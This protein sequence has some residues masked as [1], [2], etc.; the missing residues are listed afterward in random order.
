MRR[1]G[2]TSRRH[3]IR[4]GCSSPPAPRRGSPRRTTRRLR[5]ACSCSKRLRE[6]RRRSCCLPV[7]AATVGAAT[8]TRATVG[9]GPHLRSARVRSSTR[10]V[11]LLSFAGLGVTAAVVTLAFEKVLAPFEGWFDSHP[12]AAAVSRNMSVDCVVGAIAIALPAV[13]GNGY[14]PLNGILNSR[15]RRRECRSPDRRQDTCHQSDR[16]HRAFP[17]ASSRR[18]CSSAPRWEPGGGISEQRGLSSD[19]GQL[20]ARRAWQRLRQPAF[21][22]LSQRQSWCLNCQGTIFIVLPLH[23]RRPSSRRPRP[24]AL[25]AESVYETELGKRGLG[26][27]IDAR[28]KAAEEPTH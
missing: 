9:A 17:E 2:G 7:M 22:P 6:S 25:G 8:I 23:P 10:I 26:W 20:R 21:T 14:E 3:S 19:A 28:G 27:E 13:V 11:E 15:H 16:S 24:K 4:H 12:R 18:C 5:P 1:S